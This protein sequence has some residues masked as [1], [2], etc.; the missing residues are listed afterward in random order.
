MS[1][2]LAVVDWTNLT[3]GLQTAFESGVTS[4]LPVAGAILAASVIFRAVKRFLF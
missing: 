3:S 1:H 4:V 2:Y